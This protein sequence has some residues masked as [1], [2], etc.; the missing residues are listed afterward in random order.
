MKYCPICDARY[1]EEIIRFCTKDGT[2]LVDDEQPSFV[3]IPS[4]NVEETDDDIGEITVIRRKTTVPSP[5]PDI[6]EDTPFKA[7]E[8]G[9]RIVIPTSSEP[10]E[11]HVRPRTA[12]VYYP[13]P[14]PNTGKTVVLTILGTLVVLVIGAGL[15]WFLQKEAPANK[16]MNLNANLG[17]VNTNLNTSL[18][19]DSNFNFNANGGYNT[20]YNI[21]TNLNAIT[22][23]P[24][25]TPKPSPSVSPSPSPSVSPS[26]SPTPK[27]NANGQPTPSPTPRTG[28]RPPLTTNRPPGNGN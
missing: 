10:S 1:D 18:P 2:P 23:T 22:K 13:P 8:P 19:I 14:P 3:A 16:N 26:L 15:F 4:E 25:P 21:N 12:S 28:P 20:N 11:Q 24:T 27:A 7:S 17:N 5:P 9:E 6:D